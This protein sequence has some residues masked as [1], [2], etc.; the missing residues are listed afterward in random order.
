[1]RS[2]ETEEGGP[3]KVIGLLGSNVNLSAMKRPSKSG[4][5]RLKTP[6]RKKRGFAQGEEGKSKGLPT[7][8][9]KGNFGGK[10]RGG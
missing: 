10:R 2:N 3:K 7:P 4:N 1:L 8:E 6:I 5:L 9:T